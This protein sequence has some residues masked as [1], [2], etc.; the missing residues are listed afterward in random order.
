MRQESLHEWTRRQPF[1]PFVVLMTD[2]TKYEVRHPDMIMPM[3]GEVFM[4]A[5][6]RPND[7]NRGDR[8]IML[9]YFHIMRVEPLGS[10]TSDN[11]S[12]NGSGG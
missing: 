1:E 12:K 8:A 6:P 4:L 2:G 9:S 10:V 7:P 11:A 5:L 3:R